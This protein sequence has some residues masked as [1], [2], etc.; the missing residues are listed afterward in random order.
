ML[1]VT[2]KLT[3]KLVPNTFIYCLKIKKKGKKKG[4]GIWLKSCM[5]IHL[6]FLVHFVQN[7]FHTVNC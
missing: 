2:K 5:A 3:A 6:P 4:G 7:Q 1:Y